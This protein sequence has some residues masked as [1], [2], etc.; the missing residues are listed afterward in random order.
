MKKVIFWGATGQAIVLEEIVRCNGDELVAI[1]DNNE[2]L[3]SPFHNIPIFFKEKGFDDWLLLHE[4]EDLYFCVAIGGTHGLAR[5]SIH[6]YLVSKGLKSYSCKHKTAY[7]SDSALLSD[8]VQILANTSICARVNLGKQVIINT[9][10][11]IDHECQIQDGVHIAPGA[12]LAGRVIV[13]KNAFIGVGAIILP[14]IRIGT[15]AVVG[16]GA[17]V[18]KSIPPYSVAVGNP[19]RII[20]TITI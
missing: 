4:K 3:L 13:E 7:I 18:T 6:T 20:K 16:A 14:H 2:N 15:G 8:G 17:V 12:K 19:A 10:A 11:S 5:L 1:F 9:S